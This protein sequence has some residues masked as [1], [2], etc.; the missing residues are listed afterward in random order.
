MFELAIILIPRLAT[1]MARKFEFYYRQ[2]RSR[3][4][5]QFFRPKFS[6]DTLVISSHPLD[7][8]GELLVGGLHLLHKCCAEAPRFPNQRTE[9]IADFPIH[10]GFSK[11]LRDCSDKIVFESRV[12][13]LRRA[14]V[15]D[16]VRYGHES[17]GLHAGM[18][19]QPVP[20]FCP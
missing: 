3:S 9:I 7:I 14:T 10:Q 5:S 15:Q 18:C 12:D 2:S 13:C 11:T 17:A 4:R 20:D 16:L 6:D 8:G 1:R 19:S